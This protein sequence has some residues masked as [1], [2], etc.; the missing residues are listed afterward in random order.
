M[1]VNFFIKVLS[2]RGIGVCPVGLCVSLWVC[3]HVYTCMCVMCVCLYDRLSGGVVWCVLSGVV[4]VGP[5]WMSLFLSLSLS[6]CV[7]HVR[8]C[9]YPTCVCV[10]NNKCVCI[11]TRT[12]SEKSL[13]RRLYIVNVLGN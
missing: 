6:L 13:T 11:H 2:R 7:R 10:C 5:S 8:T 12:N 9:V 4:C 1:F 3:L